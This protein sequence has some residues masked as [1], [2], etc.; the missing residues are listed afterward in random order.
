M[1]RNGLPLPAGLRLTAAGTPVTVTVN[2][3]QP[4]VIPGVGAG[5]GGSVELSLT[6]ALD[7]LFHLTPGGSVTVDIPLGGT[8]GHV[9]IAFG[10]EAGAVSLSL[11]PQLAG[12]AA[13]APITLLPRF[14][15]LGPLAA[16]AAEALLP[17]VLDAL[18]AD[19]PSPNSGL[20]GAALA[21]ADALGL[22][23]GS[24]DPSFT[25]HAAQIRALTQPGAL[26]SLQTTTLPTALSTVWQA[27]GLP[28]ILTPGAGGAGVG[29]SD[30]IA[31]ATVTA[32][33]GWGTQPAL[34]VGV[35]GLS[36]GAVT[37]SA[38]KLG[39]GSGG[40]S[41]AGTVS[42]SLPP[43]A[44]SALGLALAP[45]LVI[46][47]AASALALTLLP[48]GRGLRLR[49]VGAFAARTRR[50]ARRKRHRAAHRAMGPP[51]RRAAC[52]PLVRP[53]QA[54]VERRA[55]A[56]RRSAWRGTSDERR[57]TRSV[58]APSAAA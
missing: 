12:G 22:H 28:G 40:A 39:Y 5:P 27:A 15:G 51:T 48:L 57:R 41:A 43:A 58:C 18:V 25:A 7:E 37:I 9:S 47:V 36:V 34:S 14:G 31:G 10:L 33:L 16:D 3:D 11:T 4:I 54:T 32:S 44:Q 53:D 6:A 45:A 1:A 30:V 13:V 20:A 2:T 35:D 19:L 56:G 26:S 38:L 50:R 17:A 49:A 23:G 29:W 21:V 55:E 8:W 46:D 42:V 52:S 24:S